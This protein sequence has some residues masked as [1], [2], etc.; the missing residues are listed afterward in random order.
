[1]RVKAGARAAVPP[2]SWSRSPSRSRPSPIVPFA[3]AFLISLRSSL[4][5]CA[6][7][8]ESGIYRWDTSYASGDV[9]RVGVVG[10]QVEYS[11]NGVVF[12]TSATLPTYPLLVDS[13]L[14]GVGSTISNAII[15]GALSGGSGGPDTTPPLRSNGRPTGALPFGTTTTTASLSTDEAATCRYATTAGVSME[16][17]PRGTQPS[18]RLTRKRCQACLPPRRIT[19]GSDHGMPRTIWRYRVMGP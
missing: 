8:R 13:S 6:E 11:K 1:M 10:G 18:P 7:V 9:F 3:I 2:L 16:A 19:T 5:V 4:P 15:S 12:Y 14:A 17:R